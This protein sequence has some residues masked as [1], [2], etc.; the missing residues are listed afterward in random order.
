[1]KVYLHIPLNTENI[2]PKDQIITERTEL[3][4]FKSSN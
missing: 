3:T 1:M 4:A 2:S